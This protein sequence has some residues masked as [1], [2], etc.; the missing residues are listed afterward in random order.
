MTPHQTNSIGEVVEEF[1]R[2]FLWINEGNSFMRDNE[3]RVDDWLKIKLTTLVEQAR[4][5]LIEDIRL[6]QNGW[7]IMHDRG[8]DEQ[9]EPEFAPEFGVIEDLLTALSAA[10]T[11]SSDKK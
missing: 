7:V 6:Y 5:K 11:I 2:D 1:Q 4:G 9:P 10:R 8:P 3:T